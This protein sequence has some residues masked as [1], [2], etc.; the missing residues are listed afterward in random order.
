MVLSRQTQRAGVNRCADG[1]PLL[2]LIYKKING[3]D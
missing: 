3:Y 1:T 2:G